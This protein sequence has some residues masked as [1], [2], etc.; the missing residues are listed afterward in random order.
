MKYLSSEFRNKCIIAY[1]KKIER[2]KQ[3]DKIQLTNCRHIYQRQ[4]VI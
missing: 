4:I 2:I 1:Q 3:S